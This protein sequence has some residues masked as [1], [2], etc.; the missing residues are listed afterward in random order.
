MQ[1]M[2]PEMALDLPQAIAQAIACV[3][4][5][6]AI[7]GMALLV[8]AVVLRVWPKMLQRDEISVFPNINQEFLRI[9]APEAFYPV[10]SSVAAIFTGVIVKTRN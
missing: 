7:A 4:V 9:N 10:S 5:F 3:A 2:A 1:R 8:L 6:A